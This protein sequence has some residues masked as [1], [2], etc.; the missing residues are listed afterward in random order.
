MQRLFSQRFKYLINSLKLN[1][2]FSEKMSKSALVILPNGAEEM[3]FVIAVD[4][5]RR[6]NVSFFFRLIF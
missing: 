5:L 1:R 2:N 4:V 6:S 3:E